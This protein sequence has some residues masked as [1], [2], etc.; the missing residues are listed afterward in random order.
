MKNKTTLILLLVGLMLTACGRGQLVNTTPDIPESTVTPNPCISPN[1]DAEVTKVNDLMREFDDYAELASHTPKEQLVDIIPELQRI[2]RE[3]EKQT[4][5]ACLE[6][7]KKHQISHMSVVVQTL[8]AFISNADLQLINAGI[9]QAQQQHIQYETEMARLLGITLVAPPTFPPLAGTP[10]SSATATI[11]FATN[12]SASVIT[13][14]SSPDPNAGGVSVL[15]A[16]L[17]TVAVG[18]TA[19]GAWILVEVPGQPGQKAWVDATLVA[20]SGPLPVA[21]P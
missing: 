11:I 15:E 17:T 5:P 14:L 16:G 1:L 21:T 10:E 4:V 19:D 18:Q 2:L 7:L 20:L 9:S 13:L 3:A 6:T 12:S 8:L